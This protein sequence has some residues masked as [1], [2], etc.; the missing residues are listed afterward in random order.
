MA[1]TISTILGVLFLAVG[2]LG[3]AAPGLMGMHLSVAHNV[4][5][6]VSGAVALFFRLVWCRPHPITTTKRVNFSLGALASRRREEACRGSPI[7]RT[8]TLAGE[9]PAL[10]SANRV[11]PLVPVPRI[12]AC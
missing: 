1:K 3:F 6:L 5:H 2:L 11:R 8:R 4:V 12:L 10:Q 9:T 7:R